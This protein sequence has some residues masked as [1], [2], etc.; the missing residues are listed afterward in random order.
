VDARNRAGINRFLN[1]LFGAPV[2]TD[3]FRLFAI[4][5]HL[6]HFRTYFR[7]GLTPDTFFFVDIHSF[8]HGVLFPFIRYKKSQGL[9]WLLNTLPLA[10]TVKVAVWSP[11]EGNRPKNCFGPGLVQRLRSLSMVS[12][13]GQEWLDW[14]SYMGDIDNH[15]PQRQMIGGG[16]DNLCGFFW[17]GC[18]PRSVFSLIIKPGLV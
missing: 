7:A 18:M 3:H 12:L 5:P 6:K 10:M 17:G 8:L 13:P 4:R 16:G 11:S 1:Q 2:K 14:C 9:P 15:I